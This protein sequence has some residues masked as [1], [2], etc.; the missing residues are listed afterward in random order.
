MLKNGDTIRSGGE[1]IL[2]GNYTQRIIIDSTEPVTINIDGNVT[3]TLHGNNY[4]SITFLVVKNVPE[5]TINGNDGKV[6][7][8][9]DSYCF[10]DAKNTQSTMK[11]TVEGGTYSL[12]DTD[13]PGRTGVTFCVVGKG[14]DATNLTNVF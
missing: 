8:K 2:S 11:L 1:Y 5:L 3:Y 13:Y 7:G 4:E 14:P 6:S 10:L 9:G 12:E